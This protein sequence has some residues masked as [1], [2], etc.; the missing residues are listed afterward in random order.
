MMFCSDKVD[1]PCLVFFVVLFAYRVAAYY[2]DRSIF[3]SSWRRRLL[4]PHLGLSV[5]AVCCCVALSLGLP[6]ELPQKTGDVCCRLKRVE[7][8]GSL[9]LALVC[10]SLV[11]VYVVDV[12]FLVKSRGGWNTRTCCCL[13]RKISPFSLCRLP[14]RCWWI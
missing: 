3:R 13:S 10:A 9:T 5:K 6:L 8:S 1:A 14:R 4:T 11:L 2:A 12:F 7:G